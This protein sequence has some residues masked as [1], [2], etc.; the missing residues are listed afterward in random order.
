MIENANDLLIEMNWLPHANGAKFKKPQRQ[1][2]LNLSE[3][4]QVIYNLLIE[5]SELA[6]DVLTSG[7][8]IG[9]SLLAATLLEMEMNH[10]IISLPGKRYKLL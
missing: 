2:A 6:I 10:I 1:L 8:G 7:T 5:K 4:E 3:Q 9:T